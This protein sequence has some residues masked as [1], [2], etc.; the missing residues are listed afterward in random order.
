MSKHLSLAAVVLASGALVV[1]CGGSGN[2]PAPA[3]HAPTSAAPASQPAGSAAAS[4]P[5]ASAMTLPVANCQTGS[6]IAGGSTAMQPLVEAAAE[7]YQ[8]RAP[9]DR[10]GPGRRLRHRPDPG[11]GGAIQIGNS[12][13]D[14]SASWRLLTRSALVDHQVLKQGWIMVTNPDV[15]G[16]TNLTTEQAKQIWTGAITNWKDVGGPDEA[17][18]LILRPETSG[19][20]ATFKKIVLG[21]ADEAQGQALTEDSNGAVDAG[22]RPRPRRDERHRL[23]LLP[24]EQ[25]DSSTGFSSTAWTRRSTT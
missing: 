11:R 14:A 12:D 19:T 2:S 4:S 3:S 6:I 17:I 22:R 10:P 24:A 16:V 13:V 21:G 20:R 23:R 18:V 25:G 9:V 1:A 5:A 15:T 8:P 7:S